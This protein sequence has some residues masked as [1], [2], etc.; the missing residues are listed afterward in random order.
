M[1]ITAINDKAIPFLS[2]EYYE[3]AFV[4]NFIVKQRRKRVLFELSSKKKRGHILHKLWSATDLYITDYMIPF[5]EIHSNEEIKCFLY[6]YG[7]K[8]TCY[9]MSH[10]LSGFDK[11]IMPIDKG[12]TVA[13][14]SCP[15]IL[16]F[17]DKMV[18]LGENEFYKRYLLFRNC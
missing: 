12:I 6:K 2:K 14:E 7:A 3:S 18:F 10:E 13:Q 8:S 5:P 17:S 1:N 15:T 4:N 11:S 9:V 16:I